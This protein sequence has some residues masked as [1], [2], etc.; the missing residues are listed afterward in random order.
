MLE[1]KKKGSL[2]IGGV[3]RSVEGEGEKIHRE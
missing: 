1:K 2:R 3:R